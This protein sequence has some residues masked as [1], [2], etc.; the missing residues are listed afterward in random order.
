MNEE[1][2]AQDR[3][4]SPEPQEEGIRPSPIVGIGA[5]AGGFEAL[6][7]LF[8][9]VNA[10]SDLAFVV[11]LH[12]DPDYR[13]NLTE[14]LSRCSALPV[15]EVQNGM[16]VEPGHVYVIP[17]NAVLTIENRR[18]FLKNPA[19]GVRRS[20]PFSARSRLTRARTPLA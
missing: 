12:L 5:S 14:L 9:R 2:V 10:D 3:P 20:M 15:A 19:P 8:P 13:S 1:E 6:R 17:P 16:M 18:L 7:R 4:A 11:V